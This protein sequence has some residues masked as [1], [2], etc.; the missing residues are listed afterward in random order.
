MVDHFAIYA[1]FMMAWLP[2]A[3]ADDSPSLAASAPD[4]YHVP[5]SHHLL[6]LLKSLGKELNEEIPA[7]LILV[8][9]SKG[10]AVLNA[11]MRDPK[12]ELW[13]SIRTVHFVD[14]GLSVPGVFPLRGEE[15]QQLRA[16]VRPDFEIWLHCTPR[17]V[18]DDSRPFVAHEH[19]A[20]E[21]K[22]KALGMA[23]Q[24]RMYAA[25]L[26]VSLDMH[27]DALRCFLTTG[28]DQDGGDRHCGF[29]RHW[30][31]VAEAED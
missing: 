12:E 31:A 5:A 22:C 19:D 9:F 4:E 14:A 23:I 25:G 20:F 17:Q 27:F 28:G 24:R 2:A 30:R 11:L 13:S 8:G 7:H 26:P 1:N 18:Q 29:F 16:V 3:S 21:A 6:E 15:L 10:A